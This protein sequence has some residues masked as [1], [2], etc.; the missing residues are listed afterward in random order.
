MVPF[1]KGHLFIFVGVN[2]VEWT[3][4]EGI[5]IKLLPPITLPETNSKFAP[6]NGWLEY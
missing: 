6:E 3:G 4:W 5:P 2:D 1:F